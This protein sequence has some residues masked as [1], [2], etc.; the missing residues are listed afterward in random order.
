MTTPID[1]AFKLLG[2]FHENTLELCDVAADIEDEQLSTATEK[3]RRWTTV[4][5]D[6]ASQ[7][8][9]DQQVTAP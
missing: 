5:G 6:R 8:L 9:A 1:K 4:A 7:L 3:I 2:E